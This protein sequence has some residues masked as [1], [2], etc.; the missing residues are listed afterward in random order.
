MITPAQYTSWYAVWRSASSGR[1]SRDAQGR[2]WPSSRRYSVAGVLG[3]STSRCVCGGSRQA[4]VC[5]GEEVGKEE[6]KKKKEKEEEE[7]GQARG[8]LACF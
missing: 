2:G 6:E 1:A 3:S 7:G 4:V 8:R 5:E